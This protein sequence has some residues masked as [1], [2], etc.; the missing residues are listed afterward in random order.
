MSTRRYEK[1]S[2]APSEN[3]RR[4]RLTPPFP[5]TWDDIAVM[6]VRALHRAESASRGGVVHWKNLVAAFAIEFTQA[7]IDREEAQP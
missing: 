1:Q 2:S 7:V 3:S 5:F 4:H 6:R